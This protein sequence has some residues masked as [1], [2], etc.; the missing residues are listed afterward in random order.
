MERNW[1]IIQD[2]YDDGHS[3]RQVTEK[4]S[5]YS[6]SIR[7]AIARGDL[8]SRTRAQANLR[9][10]DWE[11]VQAAYDSGKHSWRTL[12]AEFDFSLKLLSKAAADGRFVSRTSGDGLSLA[13]IDG[14]AVPATMSEERRAQ[15]SERFSLNN[16]GGKCKWYDVGGVKVQGTWERDIAMK[17]SHQGI[18]WIR[19]RKDRLIWYNLGGKIKSYAPD[20]YLPD[21]D[22]YLEIKGYWWHNDKEKMMAVAEQHPDKNIIVIEKEMFHSVM[23]TGFS[24]ILP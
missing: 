12:C 18:R 24:S 6:Q 22:L 20:F 13:Y 14:R 17:L 4:F 9:K 10:V 21:F 2:Y 15:L 3:W 7:R 5:V 11:T 8:N 23:A 16:P 1:T 19:P